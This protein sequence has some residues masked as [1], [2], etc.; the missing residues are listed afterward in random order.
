MAFNGV[1]VGTGGVDPNPLMQE[2]GKAPKK[3][4]TSKGTGLTFPCKTNASFLLVGAA[5]LLVLIGIAAG[6]SHRNDNDNP[7]VRLLFWFPFSGLVYS[8]CS[9]IPYPYSFLRIPHLP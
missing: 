3:R 1:G 7:I 6:G 9:C 2:G 4:S 8:C 5:V